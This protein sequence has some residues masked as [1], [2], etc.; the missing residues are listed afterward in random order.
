VPVKQYWIDKGLSESEAEERVRQEV[1][2]VGYKVDSNGN[3]IEQG[4]GSLFNPTEHH[5]AAIEK[6]EGKAAADRARREAS[7]RRGR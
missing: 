2:G 6:R 7:E 5:F 4:R 1:F 3:P